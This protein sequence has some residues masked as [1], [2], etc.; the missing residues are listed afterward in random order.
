MRR[1]HNSVDSRRNT[2]ASHADRP[3]ALLFSSRYRSVVDLYKRPDRAGN[4]LGLV[5]L[6]APTTTVS[7]QHRRR[8][9]DGRAL[10]CRA[11]Y[12]FARLGWGPLC[13]ARLGSDRRRPLHASVG[14]AAADQH[15]VW[16]HY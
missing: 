8:L 3:C 6:R 14:E 5:R 13:G 10:H 2:P 1:Q 12:L 16:L 7:L 4:G 9:F 11:L 15:V